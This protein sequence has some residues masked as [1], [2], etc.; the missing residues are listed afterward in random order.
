M[1][2][3]TIDR[4]ALGPVFTP[5]VLE[6]PNDDGSVLT[7]ATLE[8]P[9]RSNQP[10]VSCIPAGEYQVVYAWSDRWNRFMPFVLDVP[11]RYD[12]EF[13]VG[14]VP[15]DTDGCIIVGSEATDTGVARSQL[16]FTKFDAWACRRARYGLIVAISDPPIRPAAVAA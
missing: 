15:R 16:A 2:R 4:S 12:V 1:K 6:C 9:W 3:F 7:F 14:N 13:H 11:H 10:G 8:L 5:G